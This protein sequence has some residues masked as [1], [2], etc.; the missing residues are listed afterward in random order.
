[1]HVKELFCFTN[2][3]EEEALSPPLQNCIALPDITT[4]KEDK[5]PPPE[6][7]RTLENKN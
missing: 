1:M 7:Y 3:G 6:K 2:R 4:A 5:P